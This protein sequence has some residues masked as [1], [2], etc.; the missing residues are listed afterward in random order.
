MSASPTSRDAPELTEAMLSGT[1]W[2]KCRDDGSSI[3]GMIRLRPDQGID[4]HSHPNE[5][6]WRLVEGVLSLFDENGICSTRFDGV[7]V[8]GHG[9]VL[10]GPF[11]LQPELGIVHR[12]EEI[13]RHPDGTL[14]AGIPADRPASLTREHFRRELEEGR[15]EIGDHTYGTPLVFEPESA[16]LRIGRFTSM[17]QHVAIALGNHR[18]DTVST[19]PFATLRH[20]WLFAPS[21][22]DHESRGDVCIGNDVWIGAYAF[23]GS[24]VTI[25]DGA[26]IGAHAV[27]TRSVAPYAVVAGNPARLIRYRFAAPVIDA[28]LQIAWWTWPDEKIEAQLPWMLSTDIEAFLARADHGAGQDAAGHDGADGAS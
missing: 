25:G 26:V 5:T 22:D 12:L 27:V 9:L 14:V 21:I 4:G 20:I 19:Y 16:S 6:S 18:T 13:P 7:A 8:R 1:T 11:V 2:R 23:V 10:R 17:A 3:S 24:G 15:W 28:L